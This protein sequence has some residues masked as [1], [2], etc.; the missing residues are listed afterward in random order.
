MFCKPD[1]VLT[2]S[3]AT[4]FAGDI[5]LLDIAMVLGA[6]VPVVL[7]LVCVA[8]AAHL[9]VFR[10]ARSKLDLRVNHEAKPAF[11]YLVV[12][13]VLGCT[14]NVWFFIDNADL[15]GGS[16]LVCIGVP[17]SILLSL[18]LSLIWCNKRLEHV[19]NAP[20]LHAPPLPT[21]TLLSS[22]HVPPKKN[23]MQKTV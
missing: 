19:V 13:L 7:P 4:Q 14:L 8:F 5:M 1:Y 12:S 16:L 23:A 9:A 17:A 15:V 22:P 20:L 21:F 11:G 18:A 2:K 6:S 10:A 3:L